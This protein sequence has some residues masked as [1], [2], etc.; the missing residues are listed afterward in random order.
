MIDFVAKASAFCASHNKPWIDEEFGW[1]QSL[2]DD[3]RARQFANTN[4]QV[5]DHQGS[6]EVF[7]NL[8][9]QVKPTT[10]DI[11]TTTPLTFAAVVT[12]AQG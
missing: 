12:A 9:Y 5:R 1:Q 6:G 4:R 8:G 3:F 7:W 11:G 10:Y 2:G